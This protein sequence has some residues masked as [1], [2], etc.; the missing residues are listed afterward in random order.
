MVRADR[1]ARAYDPSIARADINFVD[2]LKHIAIYTSDGR[3]ASDVQPLVRFK[4]S[5]LSERDGSRQTTRWGGGG[6]MGMAELEAA[7]PDGRAE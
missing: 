3:M 1:A 7:T 2:E 5:C 6:R 4:I